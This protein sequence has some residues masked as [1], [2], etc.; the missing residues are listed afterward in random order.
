MI[1]VQSNLVNIL[2]RPY[3]MV[4]IIWFMLTLIIYSSE[5]LGRED[6]DLR[7]HMQDIQQIEIL[8]LQSKE[9][10]HG[11]IKFFYKLTANRMIGNY[12]DDIIENI[13]K[14]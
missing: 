8:F 13:G 14:I 5:Y 6:I 10:D 11:L 7:D 3:D 2:Y 1:E 4:H 9:E 12:Q